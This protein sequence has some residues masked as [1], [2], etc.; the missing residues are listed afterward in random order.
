M[1]PQ[2]H[3]DHICKAILTTSPRK[4]YLK[5]VRGHH[6]DHSWTPAELEELDLFQR[7]QTHRWPL[8]NSWSSKALIPAG[9]TPAAR[10]VS[11]GVT[12]TEIYSDGAP[13]TCG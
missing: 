6:G 4:Q 11:G 13:L 9:L 8:V 7:N 1:L 10:L 12:W 5:K 2:I 3:S